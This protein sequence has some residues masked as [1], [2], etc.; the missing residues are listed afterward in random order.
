MS[1][2]GASATASGRSQDA[3]PEH[4]QRPPGGGEVSD[5]TVAGVGDEELPR[6]R[7]GDAFGVQQVFGFGGGRA[8]ACAAGADPAG[9][10]VPSPTIPAGVVGRAAGGADCPEE[11]PV[12]AE[13][14]DDV[15]GGVGDP[16]GAV[17]GEGGVGGPEPVAA[18]DR[19]AAAFEAGAVAQLRTVPGGA[20]AAGPVEQVDGAA[21]AVGLGDEHARRRRRRRRRAARSAARA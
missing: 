1:P 10:Q 8:R 15:V 13:V 2:P 21:A 12:G 14:A 5:A 3:G 16:D 17:G 11:G 18:D 6:R 7:D 4:A 9:S 19:A 20:A